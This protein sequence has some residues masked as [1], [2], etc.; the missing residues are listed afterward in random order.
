MSM[1]DAQEQKSTPPPH[2]H[3]KGSFPRP[4]VWVFAGV[5]ILLTVSMGAFPFA[6]QNYATASLSNRLGSSA[7]TTTPSSEPSFP[8]VRTDDLGIRTLPLLSTEAQEGWAN[9][10]E[11]SLQAAG[12]KVFGTQWNA[13]L[14]SS[15][16]RANSWV[17]YT[18]GDPYPLGK[19]G[20]MAATALD[21][22][23]STEEQSA[24]D[25]I[26]LLITRLLPED[27]P[28]WN[29][30]SNK[31]TMAAILA[32]SETAATRFASCDSLLTRAYV[33]S[34]TF[35]GLRIDERLT[36]EPWEALQPFEDAVVA[37]PNDP[38]APIEQ[39]K[40]LTGNNSVV[41][42]G[43]HHSWWRTQIVSGTDTWQNL[44]A[45][46]DSLIDAWPDVA[47]SHLAVADA[48]SML[49]ESVNQWDMLGPFSIREFWTKAEQEY[50][51]AATLSSVPTILVGLL[52]AQIQ[53][54]EIPENLIE[55]SLLS[56]DAK[57]N[58]EVL[59]AMAT[60]SAFIGAYDQALGT[61]RNVVILG[62]FSSGGDFGSLGWCGG[63]GMGPRRAD[64]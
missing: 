29:N 6:T 64:K 44:V 3:N 22:L 31:T 20:D 56:S 35:R 36:V 58:A 40:Y 21:R 63:P 15:A 8:H 1:S 37:C 62:G 18:S 59:H 45:S 57:N 48:Y 39:F 41:D 60:A 54:S 27:E 19:P 23:S 47:A 46:M 52:R 49:A 50:T 13:F 34:L 17:S 9:N 14:D 28:G 32:L 42:Y 4:V 11:T 10:Y 30:D 38:T 12:E 7:V 24:L 33:W 43:I 25:L 16:S 26:G 53:L 51:N 2:Q 5:A 55:D 61:S